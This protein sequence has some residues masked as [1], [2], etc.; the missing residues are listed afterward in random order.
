MNH[1]KKTPEI[2]ILKIIEKAGAAQAILLI[3]NNRDLPEFSYTNLIE[4]V[5]ASMKT[6][7]SL[8]LYLEKQG[9][10]TEQKIR[11]FPNKRLFKLTPKG[12]AVGPQLAIISKV[13][14]S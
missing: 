11:G 12:L 2:S 9:L 10:M 5:D 3:Y 8:I 1:T 7:C 6:V 4:G 13:L 14:Q